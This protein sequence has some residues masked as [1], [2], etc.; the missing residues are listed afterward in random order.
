[1]RK[2]SR[3]LRNKWLVSAA[4]MLALIEIVGAGVKWG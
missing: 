3:A 2:L 4:T 1:M